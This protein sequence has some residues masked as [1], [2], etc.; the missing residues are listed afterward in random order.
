MGFRQ[1]GRRYGRCPHPALISLLFTP[2]WHSRVRSLT[3][4]GVCTLKYEQTPG[5]ARPGA[6]V[7]VIA[8]MRARVSAH[9]APGGGKGPRGRGPIRIYTSPL[10]SSP[11]KRVAH[12]KLGS[13]SQGAF[14]RGS[15]ATKERQDSLSSV[16]QASTEALRSR[17]R[18]TQ[19]S[20]ARSAESGTAGVYTKK[21]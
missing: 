15:K 19:P 1:T 10:T 21:P 7:S 9:P 12:A 6:C 11:P 8:R 4:G 3:Y 5:N 16:S 14:F 20:G 2:Y 17:C 13:P 18:E